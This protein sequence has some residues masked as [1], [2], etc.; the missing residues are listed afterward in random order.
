MVANLKVG[1]TINAFTNL[2]TTFA[3]QNPF[4]LGAFMPALGTSATLK[5]NN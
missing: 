4:A 5:T 3:P 1:M 2:T